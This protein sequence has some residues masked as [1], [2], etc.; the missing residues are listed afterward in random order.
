MVFCE[1]LNSRLVHCLD[2][3]GALHECQA[4]FRVNSSCM[5]NVYTLKEIVLQCRLKEENV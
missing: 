3:E 4:G 1:V 5:D 2:K